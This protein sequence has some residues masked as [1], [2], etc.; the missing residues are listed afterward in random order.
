[1][2]SVGN[3]YTMQGPSLSLKVETF[4]RPRTYGQIGGT[5]ALIRLIKKLKVAKD[6]VDIVYN[7][8]SI[9]VPGSPD[10]YRVRLRWHDE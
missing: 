2:S 9:S 10:N 5:K 6:L 7:Q 8:N 1:M 3:T 4:Q